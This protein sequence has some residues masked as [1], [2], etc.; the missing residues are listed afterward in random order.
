MGNKRTPGGGGGDLQS[1]EYTA[2]FGPSQGQDQ[3]AQPRE[4]SPPRLRGGNAVP[5]GSALGL[6]EGP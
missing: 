5:G 6:A 3:R 4:S 2:P 1:G